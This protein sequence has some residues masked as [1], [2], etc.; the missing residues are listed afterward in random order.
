MLVEIIVH[1][2]VI[3]PDPAKVLASLKQPI[4]IFKDV[5]CLHLF[6]I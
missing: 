1:I 3:F 5:D 4:G 6:Q 2:P